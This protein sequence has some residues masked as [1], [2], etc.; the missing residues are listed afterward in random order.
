MSEEKELLLLKID[1]SRYVEINRTKIKYQ[2]PLSFQVER[3]LKPP[4]P[5]QICSSSNSPPYPPLR[6]SPDKREKKN[7]FFLEDWKEEKQQQ[8]QQNTILEKLFYGKYDS[9]RDMA[10]NVNGG[11]KSEVLKRIL[12][13]QMRR[14]LKEDLK[15]LLTNWQSD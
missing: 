5:H 10:T 15:I 9:L 3:P 1:Q 11:Q 13:K 14:L 7:G 8:Q 2:P 12:C 6:N 4:P